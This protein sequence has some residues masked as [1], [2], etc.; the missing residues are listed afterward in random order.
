MKFYTIWQRI[1]NS[2][3][4]LYFS[5]NNLL[6]KGVKHYTK[7]ELVK[8]AYVNQKRKLRTLSRLPLSEWS[9]NPPSLVDY[10]QA[11]DKLWTQKMVNIIAS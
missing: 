2:F 6:N 4:I 5:A 7:E 3:L 9:E 10:S 11:T 8:Q 1:I